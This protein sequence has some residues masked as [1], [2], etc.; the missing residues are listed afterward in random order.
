MHVHLQSLPIRNVLGAWGTLTTFYQACC[1]WMLACIVWLLSIQLNYMYVEISGQS[2]FL[3][4]V[5]APLKK[6][7]CTSESKEES[8]GPLC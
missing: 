2:F 5:L 4:S 8:P 6:N 7:G 3:I 1:I